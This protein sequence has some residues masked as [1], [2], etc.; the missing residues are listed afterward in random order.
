MFFMWNV[1][2]ARQWQKE[3]HNWRK[4]EVK[5]GARGHSSMGPRQ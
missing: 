4:P 3:L 2:S 5:E 1:I